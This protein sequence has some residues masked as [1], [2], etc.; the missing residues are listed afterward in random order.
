MLDILI[1]HELT[2][3]V[4]VVTRYFGGTLLGT[5]GLVKAYQSAALAGLD[6]SSIIKK[7]LAL[8][9]CLTTDYNLIGKLQY[10]ISQE[11]LSLLSSEYSDI[12]SFDILV[13]VGKISS[14]KKNIT[15]LGSGTAV[16]TEKE[17]VYFA[18]LNNEIHLF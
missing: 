13:P 16:L 11:K 15:E 6:N 7:E 8:R 1:S 3:L 10:Y 4:V 17:Q 2:N 12:V 5:G 18:I 9:Y 14:F